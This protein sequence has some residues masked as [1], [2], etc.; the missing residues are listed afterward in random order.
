MI[1]EL[2]NQ[3]QQDAQDAL[4][5]VLV[6]AQKPGKLRELKAQRKALVA[7][8]GA[9]E[10]AVG[11]AEA[12]LGRRHQR[13]TELRQREAGLPDLRSAGRAAV[14]AKQALGVELAAAQNAVAAQHGA[15]DAARAAVVRAQGAL[16]ALDAD[17]AALEAV[18]LEPYKDTLA[19]LAQALQ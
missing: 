17:I 10:A 5:A 2:T 18:S 11:E 19:T 4:A 15:P 6:V 16:A 14:Q 8:I 1:D 3:A 12:E 9:L 13:L 7:R